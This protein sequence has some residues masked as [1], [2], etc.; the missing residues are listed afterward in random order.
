MNNKTQTA[1]QLLQDMTKQAETLKTNEELQQALQKAA[2][3]EFDVT[4]K[5]TGI[6]QK[7]RYPLK[8]LLT[9]EQVESIK[10][11]TARYLKENARLLEDKLVRLHLQEEPADAAEPGTKTTIEAAR[12]APQ[13]ATINCPQCGTPFTKKVPTQV[14]CCKECREAYNEAQKGGQDERKES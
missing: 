3:I 6:G 11:E 13:G 9:N 8:G 14:F 1:M 10:A 7:D 5:F 2:E 4:A 12:Q